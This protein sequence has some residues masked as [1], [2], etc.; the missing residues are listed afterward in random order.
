MADDGVAELERGADI[1]L[2]GLTAALTP[3]YLGADIVI[4]STGRLRTRDEA[5]VH[6]KGGARKV[7]VSAA[8]KGADRT[9]VGVNDSSYDPQCHDVISNASCTTNCVVPMAKVLHDS[10]GLVK[11][12]MT[13]IHAYTGDQMLLDGPHKDLRRAR[14]AAVPCPPGCGQSLTGGITLARGRH[15]AAH[16]VSCP[17]GR[18]GRLGEHCGTGSPGLHPRLRH[19]LAG[20]PPPKPALDKSIR[21]RSITSKSPP[22]GEEMTD[23]HTASQ[24]VQG[25]ILNTVRKSQDAV[26]DAIKH[27][28]DAVHAMTPSM[29]TP[30]L[31]YSDK[32]PRPEEFVANAYDFAE[33]LLASQR[34]FA[35]NV[36]HATT[37]VLTTKNGTTARK[38]DS[39]AK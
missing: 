25:E 12:F 8:A 27:W 24:E 37:P 32:L 13:T 3:H 6:L 21:V 15:C 31:P 17:H 5:A 34:K 22:R 20:S 19:A 26:V 10:F 9:V 29:P 33:Q 18:F 4:E 39:Q 38:T 16:R 7:L 35:E 36:L 30:S 2:T 14:S 11:G 1:L 23:T 28:A